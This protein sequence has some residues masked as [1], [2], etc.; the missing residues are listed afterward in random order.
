M[1]LFEKG[2]ILKT[3]FGATIKVESYLDSGGQADIYIVTYAGEKKVLKWYKPENLRDPDTFYKNLKNNIAHGSPDPVFLWPEAITEKTEGSFG[4]IMELAPEGYYTL[5]K[6]LAS[7]KYNFSSFKAMTEACIKITSAFRIL[8]NNGYSYQDLNDGNFFINPET[9]DVRIGDNDN[10]VEYGYTSGVLGK[11]RYM[12]PEIV[13]GRGTVLPDTQSDRY[14]LAAILFLILFTQHPLEGKRWLVPCLTDEYAERL[15]GT[16]PLFI[17]DPT[18]DGN[19]PVSHIHKNVVSRWSYAPDY[20]KDAFIEAFSQEA[21]KNPAR[22][23]IEVDWLKVLC[24]FRSDIVRCPLCG[25]EV[26]IVNA[27]TTKCD[28]CHAPVRISNSI[29]LRDYPI[30][31]ANGSRIYKCQLGTC[32]ADEALNPVG[33]VVSNANN[34]ASLGLK[35]KTPLTLTAT[36]PSGKIKHVAPNEVIPIKSGITVDV[37][38]TTITIN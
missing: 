12:A 11:P 13:V 9:G 21:L 6:L 1:A 19:A 23:P 10:I 7:K 30:T 34:P 31:V 2:K 25:N 4:Y 37:Y 33:I 32:N 38:G 35:N 28:T 16:E 5:S 8:H 3:D 22:R 20:L 15:Y 24:R 26:F 17:Y 18:D 27:S 36:T 14:S 29:Q